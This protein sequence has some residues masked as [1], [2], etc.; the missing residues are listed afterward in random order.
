MRMKNDPKTSFR[1][2]RIVANNI[3]YGIRKCTETPRCINHVLYPRIFGFG[4]KRPL[5]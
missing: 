2:A 3:V 4:D 1:H 5:Y